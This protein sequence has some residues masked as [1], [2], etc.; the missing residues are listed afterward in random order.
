EDRYVEIEVY[1]G[2][3][4]VKIETEDDR[5]II[6][7]MQDG[8]VYKMYHNQYCCEDVYVEEIIGDLDDLIGVPL[9]MAEE[10]TSH[11]PIEETDAYMGD[12]FTWTFYIFATFKGYVTITWFGSSNGYY[13]EEVDIER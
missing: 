11:D 13:S 2:E 5:Q 9:L 1:K 6:F 10:V 8:E 12:S 3:T 4:I 7:H